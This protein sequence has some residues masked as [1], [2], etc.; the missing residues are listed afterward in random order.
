[1]EKF[2]TK[3][4]NL[5]SFLL[6]NDGITLHRIDK[7]NPTEMWFVFEDKQKCEELESDF[8]SDM[9]VVNPKKLL[10]SQNQLKDQMFN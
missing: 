4:L 6:C 2:R 10:Y 3:N 1:M 5:A 9:A 8:W 7:T